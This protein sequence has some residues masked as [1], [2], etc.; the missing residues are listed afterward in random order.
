MPTT[1]AVCDV[2]TDTFDELVLRRSQELPVLVDFWAPWCG[3]CRTLGPVLE[4][5]AREAGGAF[6]LAK[7]DSD[8]N[9]EIAARYG[10]RGIPNVLVFRDGEAVD[11]F[12]GALPEA[13]VRTFLRPHCP[14]AADRLAAEGEAALAA[15]ELDAARTRFEQ[16]LVEDPG[17]EAARLGSAR[18]ALRTGD[19]DVARR[20]A[21]EVPLGADQHEAAQALIGGVELVAAAH[22][23]GSEQECVS[24]L[25]ADDEDLEARFAL[26]GYALA[27][28]DLRGA[29]EHYLGVVERDKSWNDEAG[30]RALLDV[31]QIV[32]TRQPLADE[33]RDRLRMLLY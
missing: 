8:R 31:F 1:D 26:G 6:E 20:L 7:V 2:S 30:R 23:T 19:L 24:R 14:S 33:F 29:L 3:P 13:Q 32:G 22:S 15:G 10:V 5:L 12:V 4:R 17:Q 16:A 21:E 28:G 9:P 25:E 27:R 11:G 18:L